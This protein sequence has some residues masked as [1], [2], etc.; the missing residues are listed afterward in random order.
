MSNTPHKGQ[1]GSEKPGHT[2]PKDMKAPQTDESKT[3]GSESN[4]SR[5]APDVRGTKPPEAHK[6]GEHRRA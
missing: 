1:S 4:F 6:S 2:P 3:A 5:T